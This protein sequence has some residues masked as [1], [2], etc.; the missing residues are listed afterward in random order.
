MM[1]VRKFY[2]FTLVLHFAENLFECEPNLGPWI[3]S[4]IGWCVQWHSTH[5]PLSPIFPFGLANVAIH[6]RRRWAEQRA[7]KRC[8]GKSGKD[9]NELLRRQAMRPTYLNIIVL[10]YYL[11][12]LTW[13]AMHHW[14]AKVC[15]SLYFGPTHSE[16]SV[17][18]A[19]T[20]AP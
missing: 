4:N 15:T 6:A 18:D 12:S 1:K 5:V 9:A 3:G 14:K 11:I 7:S 20:S 10:T 13:N 16:A 19:S 8:S 2:P 17:I